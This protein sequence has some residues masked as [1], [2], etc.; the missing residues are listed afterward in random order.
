M[1]KKRLFL[2]FL[3]PVCFLFF[4][5]LI[6]YLFISITDMT[7]SPPVYE[8]EHASITHGRDPMRKTDHLIRRPQ[9]PKGI[10]EKDFRPKVAI[11]IDDLGHDP[12]LAASFLQLNLPLSLAILPSAPFTDAIVRAANKKGREI[13]LHQPMEP[14]DYPSINPGPGALLLSMNEAEIR[15][16]LDKN[17]RQIIGAKGINNHMGSSFTENRE[18]MTWVL[19]ELKRRGL[20]YV[21]SRTTKWT[22]G[23][24]QAARIG[25]PTAERA[26]FL[27]NTPEAEAI[28]S[29]VERL[30]R[31][32]KRSGAAI[33]IGHPHNETIEILKKYRNRLKND[34]D[35]VPVS[36]LIR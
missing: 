30:L 3:L 7:V 34:V 8:E 21:D 23:F 15:Q 36:E 5:L 19:R 25:L 18:K 9:T 16:V 4:I 13:I 32:A 22:I 20:F 6:L 27:D 14:K 35:I 33:G 10:Q 24:E 17:L 2:F 12:D 1:K 29:Q 31:I 26:V 28:C 11:I